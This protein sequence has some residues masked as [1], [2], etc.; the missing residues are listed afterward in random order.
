MEAIL[1]NIAGA[2]STLVPVLYILV[3]TAALDTVTGIYAAWRSGSFNKEYLD[4]FVKTHLMDKL[5]PIVTALVAGIAI[6]GTDNGAGAALLAA[7]GAAAAAYEGVTVT[8]ILANISAASNKTKGLPKGLE[9]AVV[10]PAPTTPPAP[11]K[12]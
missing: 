4:T 1:H 11:P 8:S 10:A 3:V 6:G 2:A 9:V 7:G 12:K 5:V